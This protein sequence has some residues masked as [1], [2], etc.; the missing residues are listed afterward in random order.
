MRQAVNDSIL[1]IAD[2]AWFVSETDQ[3]KDKPDERFD[4]ALFG[5]VGEIGSLVTAIKKRLL[6]AGRRTWGVPNDEIVEELGDSLW[7]CFAIGAASG[8]GSDFVVADVRLLHT[9]IAGTD[10]RSE[11]IREVLGTNGE[12][13]LQDAPGFLTAAAEGSATLEEFRELAFLTSRTRDD[14]LVEVC[15]A[16][17]QQLTAELLRAKLPPIEKELNLSLPDRPVELVLA[18]IFWHLSAIASLYGLNLN[19][20]ASTNILKLNRRFRRGE[21]TPLYD[22]ARPDHEQIPRT[23]EVTFVTVA[24]G[25]S[26]MYLNGKRL[27]DDLTDNAYHDDGYRFHD[28][29]HLAFAAKLG[30]SPVLRKL[31]ERKRRSDPKIDEVEDGARANIV[32][33]AVINAIYIEG[34][35]VAGLTASRSTA[36]PQRL[37]ADAND[38]SFAFLKRLEALVT[39]LEVAPV[40]Y[41]EWE[42]AILSGFAIFNELRTEG[43]GTVSI[44]LKQRSVNFS[45][46]VYLDFGGRLAGIGVAD[47]DGSNILGVELD[48]REL[49]LVADAGLAEVMARREAAR[50]A[51]G[52][53]PAAR[54]E[55]SLGGW[56]GD[57]LDVRTRGAARDAMWRKGI[58]TFRATA[59]SRGTVCSAS[60]VALSDD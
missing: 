47:A 59:T 53:D 49:Q 44:D 9:E 22:N 24:R 19:D 56:R 20:V 3:A 50:I 27:G 48:D 31:M 26:R 11:K 33:E 41:W 60:V 30:W 36:Q 23:F 7:Y 21:P 54:N 10:R 8:I 46:S 15:L 2:Y 52:L 35:R 57:I 4:I 43:R 6:S 13:F 58:V 18:E 12:R 37:F 29:M 16:V 25:R 55:L 42:D 51:L 38:M 40:H 28:V 39:G 17:L 14:Q 45:P 34:M 1:T 32:E 5:L